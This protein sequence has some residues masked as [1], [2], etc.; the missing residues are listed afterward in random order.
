MTL[1]ALSDRT[2]LRVQLVA[3]LTALVALALLVS[4]FAASTALRGYLI[5]RVDE[6]LV[7]TVER[8][9]A[10]TV[11]AEPLLTSVAAWFV[12]GAT[13]SWSVAAGGLLIVTAVLVEF[14]PSG[15]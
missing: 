8:P 13:M 7:R 2:P 6:N 15:E 4:G 9:G 10:A 1:R 11:L 3:A 14:W 12:F 5:D